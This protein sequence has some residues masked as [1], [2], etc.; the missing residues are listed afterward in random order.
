MT[1]GDIV[2]L[3]IAI[4]L[5]VAAWTGLFLFPGNDRDLVAVVKVDGREVARL[6]ASSSQLARTPVALRGGTA[7]IEYGQGKARVLPDPGG[8]CPDGICWKMGWISHPGQSA[9]C[10]PNHMT[11]TLLGT[12]SD[13]DAVIR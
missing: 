6:Q 8:F 13:I 3:V 12:T 4:A 5:V 7:V 9:V 11:L 1:K 10:V 2:I